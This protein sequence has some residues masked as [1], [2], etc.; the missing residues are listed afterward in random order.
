MPLRIWLGWY[1]LASGAPKLI[2]KLQGG[3]EAVCVETEIFPSDVKQYGDFC[4]SVYPQ[5]EATFN[6]LHGIGGAGVDAGAS[7]SSAVETASSAVDAAASAS[8]AVAEVASSVDAA[9]S[10]SAV[11]ETASSVAQSADANTGLLAWISD[12]FAN[13]APTS[14]AYGMGYNLNALIPDFI[15]EPLLNFMNW[16]VE[17]ISGFEWLMELIFDLAEVGLGIMLIV[18]LFTEFA[19][20]GLLILSIAISAGSWMSYGGI[21]VLGLLF[22]IVSSIPMINLGGHDVMPLSLDYFIRPWM[23]KRKLKKRDN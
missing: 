14:T 9:A 20:I 11:V 22:S 13:L 10:A 1:W 18:G 7:A 3:W 5:G 4:T 6:A 15:E 19:A 12:F 21:V 8:T 17:M 16:S 2:H 23:R